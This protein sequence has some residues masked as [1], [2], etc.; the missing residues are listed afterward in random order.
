MVKDLQDHDI[1]V[2]Y[3]YKE[4]AVKHS[5]AINNSKKTMPTKRLHY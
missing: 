4:T 5:N 2:K 1:Q 3:I